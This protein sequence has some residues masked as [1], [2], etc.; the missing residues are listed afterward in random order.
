MT[1][2]QRSDLLNALVSLEAD[3]TS[4]KTTKSSTALS[5]DDATDKDEVTEVPPAQPAGSS[6][7][8]EIKLFLI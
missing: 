4:T 1:T 8:D 2:Q 6:K 5:Q 7:I 3:D